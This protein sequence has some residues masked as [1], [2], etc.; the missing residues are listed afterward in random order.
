MAMGVGYFSHPN[1]RHRSEGHVDRDFGNDVLTGDAG[2]D[3]LAGGAGKD[4]WRAPV[5][6]TSIDTTPATE[7][8]ASSIAAARP[9]RPARPWRRHRSFERPRRPLRPLTMPTLFS[10]RQRCD[11]RLQDQL[12]GP[13]GAGIEEI[14]FADS[15][16]WSRSDIL[17]RLDPHVFIGGSE[18]ATLTGSAGADSSWQE[19]E[20]KPWPDTA[21]PISIVS[22][23]AQERNIV[24]GSVGGTDRVEL[25]GLNSGDVAF[26]R[27]GDDLDQSHCHREYD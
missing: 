16:T 6:L 9:S 14:G 27:N 20:M 1:S 19:Q 11:D 13:P 24:E 26:F 17:T 8:I 18:N 12:S 4:V 3:I 21:A 10:G 5:G 22:K 25:A 15:T 2:T 7:T 23:R